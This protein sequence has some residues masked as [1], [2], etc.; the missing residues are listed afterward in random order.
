MALRLKKGEGGG[1]YGTSEKQKQVH[2]EARTPHS[3]HVAGQV[4]KG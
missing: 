2:V 1:E 3:I 4:H